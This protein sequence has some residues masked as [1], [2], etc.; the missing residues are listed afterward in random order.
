MVQKL[1]GYGSGRRRDRWP[2]MLVAR[3]ARIEATFQEVGREAKL[4]MLTTTA[5]RLG[6]F[7]VLRDS[8]CWS[9]Y[10]GSVSL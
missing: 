9:V 4:P 10:G 6:E 7:S 1:R 3:D 8:R 2:L 5:A